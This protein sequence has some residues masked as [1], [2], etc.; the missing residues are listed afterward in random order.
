MKFSILATLLLLPTF[1]LAKGSKV[2][3][4]RAASLIRQPGVEKCLAVVENN[5]RGLAEFESISE[6]SMKTDESSSTTTF[7]LKGF[8]VSGDIMSGSWEILVT[9]RSA[10]EGRTAECKITKNEE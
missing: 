1:A 4:E 6:I 7:K 8:N 9:E 5:K 10:E 2:S 3:A